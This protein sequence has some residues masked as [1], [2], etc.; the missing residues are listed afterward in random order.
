MSDKKRAGFYIVHKI[1]QDGLRTDIPYCV[2]HDVA[3]IEKQVWEEVRGGGILYRVIGDKCPEP[4]CHS[5]RELA[6]E[7]MGSA[8]EFKRATGGL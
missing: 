8:T 4:E 2:Y 3:L 7:L 1:N 5:V 6:A